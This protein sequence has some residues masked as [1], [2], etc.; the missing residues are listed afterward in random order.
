MKKQEV[1]AYI[2]WIGIIAAIPVLSTDDAGFAAETVNRTGIP[3]A[4]ITMT[5]P[6]ASLGVLAVVFLG[7]PSAKL[8]APR[9][10]A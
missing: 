3:I 4:E 10:R 2:D 1:R 6:G 9:T 8:A 7:V 5:V